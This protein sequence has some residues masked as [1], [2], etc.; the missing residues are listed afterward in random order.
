MRR[1]SVRRLGQVVICLVLVAAFLPAQP[2]GKKALNLEDYD[3]WSRIGSA[4]L[5][6][7]GGWIAYS[8]NLNK[9]E[10]RFFVKNLAADR[11]A[12]V[13][14][15]GRPEFSDDSKWIAYLISPSE[16]ERDR[17][18]KANQPVVN[19]AELRNL[20]TGETVSYD[21]AQT[22]S[23]AA[24]SKYFLVKKT[25]TSKD[26]KHNGTD[27]LLRNLTTGRDENV[28]SVG[29]FQVN[30]PGSVL[31]YIVD[32]ADQAGNGL[33]LLNLAT[34]IRTI[35]DSAAADYAQLAWDEAGT[36]VGIVKGNKKKGFLQKENVLLAVRGLDKGE[37]RVTVFDPA[38]DPSFPKDMVVSEFGA[39]RWA[40]D[41][42]KLFFGIKEQAPE[43]EKTDRAKAAPVANVDVWHFADEQI[44]SVQMQRAAQERNRT[45]MSVLHLDGP[46][47]VRLTDDSLR[48][49]QPTEDGRF[50][51][52]S[53]P[54]PYISDLNWGGGTADYYL[55]DTATGR[56][57]LFE[58]KLSR[59]MGLSPDGRWFLYLKNK[60]VFA[61]D[62]TTGKTA[63]L[64]AASPVS[65]VNTD[66]DHPYELPTW[67]VAG[68]TKD[69]K[70]VILNHRFDL[71]R[72]PLGG[73]TPTN[74]TTGVGE[75]DQVVFR[76]VDLDPDDK[77]IDTDKPLLLSAAGEWTKK[78][79]F[80]RLDPGQAPKPLVFEDKLFGRLMK[81]KSADVFLFT[82]QTFVD[83]PDYC[84]SDGT[85]AHPKKVTEANPQQAEYA[86]G[87]RILVDF[88][89][90]K[91]RRLQAT[92][93]LPANYE[94]GKRYPMVVYFY[95]KVSNQHHQFSMPVYDDRPHMSVYASNGYL[96]LMPDIVYE[97]GRPGSSALDCVTS[98][99]RKTIELGYADPKRIGIQ[100][101]SWGGYETSYIATQTDLFACVVTGAPPTDLVSF[102]DTLYKSTGTNQSGITEKGQV[103]MGVS[104]W[105]D[106]K[107][108]EDQSAIF[109]ATKIRAPILI[110]HGTADG[111]VDWVQGLEFYNAGRRLGKKIILLSYPDEQHHL[112]K[113]ENQVD[114][115]TR[116]RQFF[117]HYL[118][119]EPAADW[120]TSGVPFLK[121]KTAEPGKA[122]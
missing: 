44:Q 112:A 85:F 77:F 103:R 122:G 5:S 16:E 81:A 13:K 53:D 25:K 61:F 76:Y 87:S 72:L 2:A 33:V 91:G 47:F 98:A 23:F 102:Y 21:N 97:I 42:S 116:M 96:V 86:W 50:G 71:W 40:K 55:V 30:K 70:A 39:L 34:G 29:A 17:L 52:G 35:V 114:F 120:I 118:K 93:T 24:G 28:G 43:P 65:F 110:L 31:A 80:Y 26:A 108:Y 74:F 32:A 59:T 99:T 56:R 15:G 12:E 90:S 89:N 68:W 111:A 100:G 27:L 83:F 60:R 45:W 75:K 79:G 6:P 41:A 66:D 109:N 62:L 14:G 10:A 121:K 107:L 67:G 64:S 36:A 54:K 58:K 101:H 38:K 9:G 37:P 92:L 7:D 51:I 19:K 48:Q 18:Q 115:Q 105:D 57:T 73:G 94:K 117:D 11:T 106:I 63:N 46:Q 22:F 84:V 4:A 69:G 20:A 78:S 8:Y 104:P 119:G 95:E 82:T 1:M 3:K 88:K 113:K 49:F